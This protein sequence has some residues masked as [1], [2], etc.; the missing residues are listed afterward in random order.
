MI[1]KDEGQQW[2]VHGVLVVRKGDK[3]TARLDASDTVRDILNALQQQVTELKGKARMA[4]GWRQWLR[5]SDG[6]LFAL[7]E[8]LDQWT[9]DYDAL[10]SPSII[11]QEERTCRVK[12]C[13]LPE[14][15]L[16]LHRNA[17]GYVW[18]NRLKPIAQEEQR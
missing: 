14:N 10:T 12:E 1:A 4:E 17:D 8:A 3:R 11:A 13:V 7:G 16:D 15:H 18:Y 5:E 9:K 6:D 2:E